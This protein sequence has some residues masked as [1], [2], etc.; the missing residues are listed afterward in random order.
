MAKAR[1]ATEASLHDTRGKL[2]ATRADLTVAAK[3]VEKATADR[4]KAEDAAHA[5]HSAGEASEAKLAAVADLFKQSGARVKALERDKQEHE[6]TIH[7]LEARAS[8]GAG[9]LQPSALPILETLIAGFHG[10]GAA[11]SINDVLTTLV[12]QMAKQFPRVALFRVKKSHL[13]GEQQIGFDL[14]TDIA[15][16]VI[17][18]GMDS[19]LA[20]AASSGRLE[21]LKGNELKEGGGAVFSGSPKHALAV[22]IMVA[23]EPL[24]ILY[25]DDSGT[26][27][28]LGRDGE[29]DARYAE[30]M[31]Q[32]AAALIA[33]L[34]NELKAIT[35]LRAYAAS[36]LRELE[37][38]HESDVQGGLAGEELQARLKGNVDYARDVY[39]ARVTHESTDAAPF[40]EDE[41][42][43]MIASQNGSAFGRDLTAAAGRSDAPSART[44]S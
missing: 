10:L 19:L 17:P 5:A 25:V 32:H 36:L 18:L 34:T 2:D 21:R 27:A 37:Q 43:I 20:H 41:L 11:K 3:N 4:A 39:N 24:A 38:M 6:K 26:A 31:Q 13:Q 15:K 42:S 16:V 33:R 23:G 9:P 7:E 35:E 8:G 1:A 29:L 14:K 30:A 22:P 12:A 40:F 28:D 44:A